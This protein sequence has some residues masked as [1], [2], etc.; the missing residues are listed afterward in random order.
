MRINNV[1]LVFVYICSLR[2]YVKEVYYR[3][4]KSNKIQPFYCNKKSDLLVIHIKST[5]QFLA[6]ISQSFRFDH[7]L[8][9]IKKMF[10]QMFQSPWS[11]LKA[12]YRHM[13]SVHFGFYPIIYDH[14]NVPEM[15]SYG[16]NTRYLIAA[17]GSL[18]LVLDL[19]FIFIANGFTLGVDPRPFYRLLTRI[20]PNTMQQRDI[21]ALGAYVSIPWTYWNLLFDK[22]PH[23]KI[24][25][26]IN[27]QTNIIKYQAKRE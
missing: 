9:L 10:H 22:L 21:I 24:L 20:W 3:S 19:L 12:L 13:E 5:T 18:L 15:N 16:F 4:R 26:V 11:L 2:D 25:M 14:K 1:S 23:G 8:S 17:I 27:K 6:S 7:N